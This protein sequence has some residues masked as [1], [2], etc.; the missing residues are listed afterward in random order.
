[1]DTIFVRQLAGAR[2]MSGWGLF[3]LAYLAAAASVVFVWWWAPGFFLAMFLLIS[4]LHFSGDPD[5]D[6][7][8][9]FRTL[10]GGVVIVGPLI[11][12]AAEVTQLFAF[13]SGDGSARAIVAA[14]Q[15]LAW[16]WVVATGAVA[17]AGAKRH[18]ARSAELVSVTALLCL[19]PPLIAFTL[20]FCF[21]HSARHALRTRE[22]SNAG[23]F[24]HL[25]RVAAG[26]MLV[27]VVGAVI[28]WWLSN[29]QPLDMRL[30]Q[31][32]FV[33][34]AA[35]TVPH[36]AIVERVRFSGW[37]KGRSNRGAATGIQQP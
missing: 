24:S 30:A 15:W 35:L 36:M 28:L 37:V 33:G 12:H 32:L 11:L 21:M 6:M 20:Y 26:P 22:Y 14:L 2:S 7:S 31:L 9:W 29:D 18:P 10:H 16:P 1:L 13:L 3:S 23:T 8:A 34:L 25:L 17:I 27:T 4:A 19:A 5:G